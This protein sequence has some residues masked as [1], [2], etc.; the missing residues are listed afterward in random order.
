PGLV[1][2]P[3]VAGAPVLGE[4][5]QPWQRKAEVAAGVGDLVGPAGA[6]QPV[7][8][9]VEVGLGDGDAVEVDHGGLQLGG[10]RVVGAARVGKTSHKG[11]LL[12]G[13]PVVGVP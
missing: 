4:V 5:A 3:V 8:K 7:V 6:G 1:L 11:R 12:G 13:P 2:A 10:R 9:V